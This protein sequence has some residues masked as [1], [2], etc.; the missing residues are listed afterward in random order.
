MNGRALTNGRRRRSL[1]ATAAVLLVVLGLLLCPAALLGA[2]PTLLLALALAAA[3]GR[4]ITEGPMAGD[5]R[6]NPFKDPL[7]AAIRLSPAERADIVAFLKTLTDRALTRDPRFADPFARK[8]ARHQVR[9]AQR[10]VIDGSR[11]G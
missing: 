8:R 3:G 6:A 11:S 5:G 2:A 4:N 7:V 9:A 1:A 10:Q